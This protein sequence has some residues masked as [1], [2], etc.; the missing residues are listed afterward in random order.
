M[1]FVPAMASGTHYSLEM[2]F[3]Q[4]SGHYCVSL[5]AHEHHSVLYVLVYKSC[6]VTTWGI[7]VSGVR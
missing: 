2:H 1:G 5:E 4:V 6:G 7:T 3:T